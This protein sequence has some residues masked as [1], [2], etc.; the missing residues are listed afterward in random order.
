MVRLAELQAAGVGSRFAFPEAHMAQSDRYRRASCS[1]AVYLRR[2][3]QQL[4]DVQQRVALQL[5]VTWRP[6]STLMPEG[7]ATQCFHA[8]SSAQ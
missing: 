3:M 2:K 4:E 8:A 7:R 1:C 6:L 5:G